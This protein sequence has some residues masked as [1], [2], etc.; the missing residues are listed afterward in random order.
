L[1][2]KTKAT[3]P[4][5]AKAKSPARGKAQALNTLSVT[6]AAQAIARG[7]ITSE[8][9]VAACLDHIDLHDGKV[10]AWAYLNPAQ[11]LAEARARDREM[12]KNGPRGPLH[13]VPIAVKDVIDTADMPTQMGSDIYEGW[14]PRTDAACVALVRKAGAVILGK[15][16][17]CEL[18]GIAPRETMN[19]LDPTRTPGGSSSGS[20]AAVADHMAPA[21]FGTQTGGSVL[22]PA[23]FCGVVGYKPTYNMINRAGLKFAA[24]SLDTM[25]IMART[26]EDV[27]LIADVC[28]DRPPQVLH[29][30]TSPPRIGVCRNVMWD[31]CASAETKAALEAAAS[32][33]KA[34][35]A[36]VKDFVLDAPFEKLFAERGTINDYERAC[37]LAWE[38]A[39][40]RGKLSP[41]M[42]KTVEQ[43]LALPHARYQEASRLAETCR[44]RLE[45]MMKSFD[46]LITPAADGEA[47]VGL[48]Y[49][50]NPAFQALWTM[51]HVPTI[52]LPLAQGP[53]GMPVGVQLVGKRWQDHALLEAAQWTMEAHG[54]VR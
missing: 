42:T 28:I 48:H 21:A 33:A 40:H 52:T 43:G 20:A 35:G 30:L 1:P 37:G 2:S 25:G 17:T 3:P 50:G 49:A 53:N 15:T 4:A 16:V 19:P 36:A 24:E 26:V 8:A 10:R 46:V 38:W 11:A 39:H 54:L 31:G 44:L 6:A 12:K 7:D 47:P 45:E 51:L 5:K 22:R 34:A 14:Q 32:R 18:A 29:K 13:G 41:Q 23:S 9:L 27:A